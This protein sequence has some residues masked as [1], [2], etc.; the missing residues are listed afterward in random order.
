[1]IVFPI[2][3]INLGLRILGVR[4]DGYHNLETIFYP[5]PLKDMLEIIIYPEENK[6]QFTSSGFA[7]N[8]NIADNLCI[9]AYNLLKMDFPE[10]PSLKIHLHKNIPMGAGLGGGS[11]DAAFIL[12]LLNEQLQLN[13]SKDKLMKYAFKL[14]SDCPFFILN[15]PCI[16]KGRG[17][18]L[19][20]INL[21]LSN[22][23]L[24]LVNPDIHVNTAEAFAGLRLSEFKKDQ[25]SLKQIIQQPVGSWKDV[26]ENDFEEGVFKNFPVIKNIKQSLYN[27]G[28]TYVSMSGSGSTMYGL[29]DKKS[30]PEIN[31]EPNY[32]I[33]QLSL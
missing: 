8:G 28:A 19:E 24:F 22:F 32:F 14:G 4:E 10:L 25:L 11:A 9:K 2:C 23:N 3:K 31:F 5:V 33:R 18:V 12:S 26:L 15:K 1:M 30:N 17:E 27:Q 16:G 21:N 29:F 13:L 6:V 7:I 20:E